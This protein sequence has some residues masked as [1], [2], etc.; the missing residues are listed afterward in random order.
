MTAAPLHPAAFLDRDGVINVDHGY[1]YRREDFAFVAGT[2]EAAA[3][4]HA[5]GFAL[6]VV[7]N[8]SGI[9]RGLYTE[10]DFHALTDW[11][12]GEFARAGAP[13]AGVY[14]CPHHPQEAQGAYRCDCRCRKPAPGM[15]LDAARDLQIDLARSVMFGDKRSDL[16]AAQAAGVP[17]R[18]LLGLNAAAVPDASKLG[19]LA[20][21]AFR[22]L[23]DAVDAL[24]ARPR[25]RSAA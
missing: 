24:G 6:V 3:K 23:A 22:S 4:L 19:N 10:A 11:M 15:L 16:E 18:V 14:W 25:D 17:Q 5:L 12:R 8:Q 2:L 7:T 1:T 13:L 9:G 20:T 21:C